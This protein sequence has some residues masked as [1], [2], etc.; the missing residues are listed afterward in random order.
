MVTSSSC[1]IQRC[2]QKLG[3]VH[4]KLRKPNALR[5]RE[6]EQKGKHEILRMEKHFASIKIS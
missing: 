6:T 3:K 5:K 2:M 1:I 4:E